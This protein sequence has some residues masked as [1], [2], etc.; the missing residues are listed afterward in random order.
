MFTHPPRILLI[1]LILPSLLLPSCGKTEEAASPLLDG[2]AAA[3]GEA[4]NTSSDQPAPVQELSDLELASEFRSLLSIAFESSSKMPLNPHLKNRARGQEQAVLAAIELGQH[5]LAYEYTEQIPNWRR[6]TS[7]ANLAKAELER[8]PA[9][10]V[11]WL[12]QRAAKVADAP[13]AEVVD[14]DWRRDRIR[15]KIAAAYLMQ[16]KEELAKSFALGVAPSEA[17]HFE[18]VHASQL[19]AEEFDQQLESVPALMGAASFEQARSILSNLALLHAAFYADVARRTQAQASIEEHWVS[20]PM[21]VRIELVIEMANAAVAHADQ[22][23]AA[24]LLDQAKELINGFEWTPDV[25][26]QLYA[27][28]AKV[29]AKAGDAQLA[30]SELDAAM[31]LYMSERSKIVDIYRAGVLRPVAEA[32]TEAGAV[33]SAE[34]CYGRALEESFLNPNSR[35]RALD[36]TANAASMALCGFVPSSELAARMQ[37]QLE[38]LS[39]PW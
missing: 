11:E 37:A 38:S 34:Q 4:A 22:R 6:G 7:L 32:Y 16:G 39:A 17:S 15:S 29:R 18:S 33:S 5:E 21:L 13:A 28:V 24:E 12:L 10:E 25:Y 3:E 30:I 1:A 9:A 20:V 27:A 2:L 8:A 36:L 35:P 14:Q 26:I 19:S 23:G 31:S